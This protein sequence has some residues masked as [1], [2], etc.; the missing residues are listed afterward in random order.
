M[1]LQTKLASS[2][3][4]LLKHCHFLLHHQIK[5]FKSPT[6]TRF[7]VICLGTTSLDPH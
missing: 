2:P 1:I 5:A 4:I 6:T 7:V 3:G